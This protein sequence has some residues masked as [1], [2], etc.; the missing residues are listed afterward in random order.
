MTVRVDLDGENLDGGCAVDA[1]RHQRRDHRLG[2][3][4]AATPR[5]PAPVQHEHRPHDA[6]AEQLLG[7]GRQGCG[8]IFGVE[9]QRH[10]QRRA[11]PAVGAPAP[12][13]LRSPWS[14]H[15]DPPAPG[16]Q[17]LVHHHALQRRRAARRERQRQRQHRRRAHLPLGLHQRRLAST[18]RRDHLDTYTVAAGTYTVRL[19]VTDSGGDFVETTR[20]TVGP[21]QPPTATDQTVTTPEETVK[22]DHPRRDRSEG[23]AL[24]FAR[25]APDPRTARSPAPRR[26]HLHAGAQLQ[27]PRLASAS[28]S[29]TPAAT[30]TNGLVTSTSP[31]STTPRSPATSPPGHARTASTGDPGRQRRGRRPAH[32]HDRVA[33][34]Q[35]LRSAAP[36]RRAPTGRTPNENGSDTFTY[37]ATTRRHGLRAT[38]PPHD[39]D[40][41]VNDLPVAD[42]QMGATR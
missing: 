32:L 11:R 41:A 3:P 9:R 30:S 24:T 38:S 17:R 27:R 7:A 8:S 2:C 19:R 40:H 25:S 35:G 5:C 29:P 14:G 39:H 36:A 10:D 20:V 23:A 18:P 15:A 4:P 26:T 28:G 33:A 34:D 16:H 6:R 13:R 42:D 22:L 37:P 21:N 1:H 31:R 12:T